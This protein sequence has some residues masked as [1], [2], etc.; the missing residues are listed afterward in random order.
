MRILFS[1]LLTCLFAAG[2]FAQTPSPAS[3]TFPVNGTLDKHL[4]K[5]VL[6]HGTVHVDASTVLKDATVVLFRGQIQDVNP[7]SITGPAVR[8]DLTG[9]HLYPSFVDLH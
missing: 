6:E 5:I 1:L 9:Y 3:S 7:E 2:V 8:L 4:V